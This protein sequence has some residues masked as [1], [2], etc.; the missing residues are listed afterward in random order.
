VNRLAYPLSFLLAWLGWAGCSYYS[1]TGASIPA[2]LNTIA[3]PFVEDN[4]ISTVT[5]LDEQMTRLL[6]DRFVGQTRLSL[7]PDTEAAD[8]VLT[9]KIDRYA[10]EPTS[11]SGGERATLN[12]VTLTVSVVYQDR[13]HNEEVLRQTFSNFEDYDVVDLSGEASAARNA[14]V[15]IADDI[16]NR[17][18]SNW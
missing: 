18:T 9:V 8:V 5:G 7:Q 12:R 4:S 17:A 2:H 14:L 3:I 13:V 1:F 6:T 15:K 16:F 10:N 11:V